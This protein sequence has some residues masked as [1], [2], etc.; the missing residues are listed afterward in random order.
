MGD[1]AASHLHSA[2]FFPD[3]D[4][5]AI[6]DLGL[7]R[8][9]IATVNQQNGDLLALP[10]LSIA[11]PKGAGPRHM[12]WSGDG[13]YLYILNELNSTVAVAGPLTDGEPMAIT[14]TIS[15]LPGAF[16]G[17]NYCADIHLSPDGNTLYA[18]NRGHNSI[19]SYRVN[20]GDGGLALLEHTP[21]H[22]AYPRNF[23]IAPDGNSLFVANQNSSNL[24]TYRIDKDGRLIYNRSY[25]TPTPVCIEF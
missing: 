24:S 6:A 12:V 5:V 11:L 14:Q 7:D 4:G 3:G 19:V 10:Q 18:S 8:I 17:K 15:T 16:N 22:G 23:A 9:W 13:A 1:A 20:S 21:T 2:A 25:T